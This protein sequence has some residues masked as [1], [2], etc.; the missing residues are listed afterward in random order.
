MKMGALAALVVC[1]LTL[2][3]GC[4]KS[5]DMLERSKAPGAIPQVGS[6]P[7][8]EQSVGTPPAGGQAAPAAP[9]GDAGASN[10]GGDTGGSDDSADDGDE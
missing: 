4:P 1:L 9:A 5:N 8:G 7:P 6:V 10:A 2:L 3:A